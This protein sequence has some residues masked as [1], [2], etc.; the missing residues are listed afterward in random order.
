MLIE[1]KKQG[2]ATFGFATSPEDSAQMAMSGVDALVLNLGWTHETHDI[3][4]KADRI[5]HAVA[6]VNEMLEAVEA[7]GKDTVCLFFGGSITSPEDTAELY[8]RTGILGFGGGSA[9]ERI[10]V[11]K[12]VTNTV[13][14]FCSVQ[15]RKGSAPFGEG[16]GEMVGASPAMLKTYEM[17]KRVAPFDVSVCIEGESGVGKELVATQLHRLSQRASLPFITLNCGAIPDTLIESELFGH[18]RGAFTGAVSR[19]LGKFELADR[20]T[21]FLDEVAEL[22]PKAQVCLLRVIQQKE[23]SRVG[24]EAK[25]PVDVRIISATHQDLRSR[26]AEGKFRTD[27]FYRLNTI[28]LEVPPLRKR[29]QDVPALVFR[30]LDDIG[31]QF[32]KRVLGTTPDFMGRLMKHSWPGNVR[33]LRHVLC[34]ALL[35][36][37][38]PVLQGEGFMP[39]PLSHN[40]L[41]APTESSRERAYAMDEENNALIDALKVSGGNKSK[42]ARILGISRKTLYS[43]LKEVKSL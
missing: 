3:F 18:E 35:L 12:L 37:D 13:R 24:G 15:L 17:I 42:A 22:S 43:K 5:Q 34:R 8:R 25:I 26:V 16:L 36:E 32:R 33:E 31:T 20:G 40:R 10:P 11:V 14:Q 4:E 30:L 41:Q 9:F 38:G 2:F 21:L 1:A 39:E 29:K 28:T 27:L 19:R 7:T 23:I 6:R